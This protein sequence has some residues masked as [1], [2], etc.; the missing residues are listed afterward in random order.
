MSGNRVRLFKRRAL[1]FL[2]EAKR[3]LN[4]GYYDIGSFHVE[5]ALQL[6]IKAVIFELFGKEYEGHGIRELLGYLSKLLKENEYE[7]L[8]KKVNERV[9]GM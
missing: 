1:R 5:Q 8:A 3:D 7:E 4:E 9:S 6:Y 2:D